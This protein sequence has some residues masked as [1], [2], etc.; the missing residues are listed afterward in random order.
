MRNCLKV[1]RINAGGIPAKMVQFQ[2]RRDR[3][4]Q[5]FI[6]EAMRKGVFSINEKLSISTGQLPASPQ[7]AIARLP[8]LVPNINSSIFSHRSSSS[9]GFG[10]GPS[11]PLPVLYIVVVGKGCV[12]VIF[13]SLQQLC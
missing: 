4:N 1:E 11:Q 6:D 13:S 5:K 10:D 2:F 12:D 9:L 7:P 8:N 3:S